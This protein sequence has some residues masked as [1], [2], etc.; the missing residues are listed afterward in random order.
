MIRK[1]VFLCFFLLCVTNL[2]GG[3][4]HY[5]VEFDTS[6]FSLEVQ[7]FD[8]TLATVI[9]WGEMHPSGLGGEYSLPSM[10][11]SFAISCE[12]TNIVIKNVKIA[13]G[14]KL[15]LE[16][17]VSLVQFETMN[18]DRLEID[19]SIAAKLYEHEVSPVTVIAR[20]NF[21][22]V[23]DI[24]AVKISPLRYNIR[25]L[26]MQLYTSIEFDIEY[27]DAPMI[28]AR[29]LNEDKLLQGDIAVAR[30]LV[31]NPEFF[32]NRIPT[33]IGNETKLWS[34]GST[35]EVVTQNKS[36]FGVPT[37]QYCV[38]TNRKLA[39]AFEKLVSLKKI[40]GFDA[41]IV[42]MEDI[43]ENENF[44]K[45]DTISRIYDDAGKLRRYLFF[46]HQNGTRFVL[47]GGKPPIVPIRYAHCSFANE[48]DECEKDIPTDL[49]FGNVSDNWRK[50]G[51]R[52]F[53]RILLNAVDGLPFPHD[54]LDF[55]YQLYVGRLLCKTPQE[56]INYTNKLEDYSF[57]P[58]NGDYGYLSEGFV[59]FS[60]G[61][62]MASEF[63]PKDAPY[64]SPGMILPHIKPVIPN[65][66]VSTQKLDTPLG[67]DLMRKLMT[68]KYGFFS[69][70][71]H[72]SPEGISV[73]YYYPYEANSYSHGVSAL[74]RE[75]VYLPEEEFN[76]LDNLNNIHFP[77]YSYTMAC[78]TTPFDSPKY[79]GYGMYNPAYDGLTYNFG[80]S[81]TLG[82]NYGG[83]AY[84][85]NTR[86]GFFQRNDYMMAKYFDL[87][88]IGYEENSHLIYCGVAEAISKMKN[89]SPASND[90]CRVSHNL[91]G[92]PAVVFWRR[93][94]I[95]AGDYEVVR[96]SDRI[97]VIDHN[98]ATIPQR[99]A[100]AVEPNGNVHKMHFYQSTVSFNDIH[101]SSIIYVVANEFKPYIGD[102]MIQNVNMNIS[103]Y[104]HVNTLLMGGKVI[105]GEYVQKGEVVIKDGTSV[106]YDTQDAYIRGGTIIKPNATLIVKAKNR[107]NVEDIS[108]ERNGKL[109]IYSDT[110]FLPSSSIGEGEI[111]VYKYNKYHEDQEELV[112]RKSAQLV[113]SNQALPYTPML[114]VGKEW[115]YTIFP[116]RQW[117][118]KPDDRELI[119][120]IEECREIDGKKYYI[121]GD[122]ENGVRD[123]SDLEDLEGYRFMVED[124]DKRQVSLGIISEDNEISRD[125]VTYDFSNLSNGWISND[126]KL[127][128]ASPDVYEAFGKSYNAFRSG[129]GRVMLVEGLGIITAP[130]YESDLGTHYFGTL[131]EGPCLETTCL[132]CMRP[133]LYKVVDGAGETIYYL[134]NARPGYMASRISVGE[135]MENIEITNS[136]INVQ[137]SGEIG[138]LAIYTPTGAQVRSV[139]VSDTHFSLPLAEFAPGVYILRVSGV[140][141][142]FTVR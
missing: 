36:A 31:V 70:A 41:G 95:I 32:E 17:P 130:E 142:K 109:I 89:V 76:G 132:D 5:K 42:C 48:L 35:Q 120:K 24:L 1:A 44:S 123:N 117:D 83:V 30:A 85:G 78:T 9:T 72:G 119:L 108:I 38:V 88:K 58:G 60:Y 110:V 87:S 67:S 64:N 53:G 63:T 77:S 28:K 52:S 27:T 124:C 51:G 13:N 21:Q 129:S 136:S 128:G 66:T 56:V 75:R 14:D 25:D 65:L 99:Y 37:Y 84:L 133:K 55:S 116:M 121:F 39:P 4:I 59:N 62:I 82:Q 57:N 127:F 86:L 102:A 118:I 101:Q 81:Y 3:T 49:Y 97:D 40:Q 114:E 7:E 73:R 34:Y 112:K 134:P 131:L 115:H 140:S 98:G 33:V 11:V 61:F 6:N 47:L 74:D 71:S 68:K 29:S 137:Y 16:H 54:D 113:N 69:L 23:S 46:A 20:E 2:W 107:I 45:G 106:A 22:N 126:E 125:I 135:D 15:Q 96:K 18:G 104:F 19:K 141:R 139:Y 80:E 10:H 94:P 90:Y 8:D 92:D 111:R 105:P 26:T 50:G 12:A 79:D 91:I 93:A 122:Y 100:V 138:E 103:Q 43:L